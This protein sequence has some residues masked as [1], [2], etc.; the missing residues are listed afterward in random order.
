MSPG[1]HSPLQRALH[2]LGQ[3]GM[4]IIDGGSTDVVKM[5]CSRIMAVLPTGL[6][7]QVWPMAGPP[8]CCLSAGIGQCRRLI[9]LQQ[10]KWGRKEGLRAQG[11][12]LSTSPARHPPMA[13]GAWHG[14]LCCSPG[15]SRAA[16]GLEQE[17][18]AREL[19]LVCVSHSL[20]QNRR[21]GWVLCQDGFVLWAQIPLVQADWGNAPCSC[22]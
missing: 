2:S 16:T 12:Q 17:S 5:P 20:E 11:L 21:S 22:H 1:P 19:W 3:V 18:R 7:L 15:T 14:Q 10:I 8:N 4:V 13:Q 9:A 6:L